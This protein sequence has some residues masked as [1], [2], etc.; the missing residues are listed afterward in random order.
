M[1][2]EKLNEM[3]REIKTAILREQEIEIELKSGEIID[4]VPER[5]VV[6]GDGLYLEIENRFFSIIE[7]KEVTLNSI[8]NVI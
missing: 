6:N 5:F 2:D 4:G 1:E 3:I 8:L 7:F